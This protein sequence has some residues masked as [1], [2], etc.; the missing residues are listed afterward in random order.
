M[1]PPE[2]AQA[3]FNGSLQRREHSVPPPAVRRGQQEHLYR[4]PRRLNDFRCDRDSRSA[5]SRGPALLKECVLLQRLDRFAPEFRCAPVGRLVQAGLPQ[6]SLSVPEA[7]EDAPAAQDRLPLAASGPEQ[8]APR[9][10]QKPSPAN[11]FMHANQPRD[12]A[13]RL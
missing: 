6:D 2:V 1:V 8:P 13:D 10:F 7:A 4:V 9:V 3:R 11:L 5:A 12:A